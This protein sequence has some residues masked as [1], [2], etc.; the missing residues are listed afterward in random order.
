MVGLT[1]IENENKKQ[2]IFQLNK[3]TLIVLL[4]NPLTLCAKLGVFSCFC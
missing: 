1:K 2:C 4:H 3:Q